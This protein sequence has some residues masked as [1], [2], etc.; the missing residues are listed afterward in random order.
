MTKCQFCEGNLQVLVQFFELFKGMN[1][2]TIPIY[3]RDADDVQINF[4]EEKIIVNFTTRYYMLV[5]F[6]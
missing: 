4:Q 6:N 2:I 3:V 1:S 5:F